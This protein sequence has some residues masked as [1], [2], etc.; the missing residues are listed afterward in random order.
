[1]TQRPRVVALVLVVLIVGSV[2]A[3]VSPAT[4]A[5]A[6]TDN[7]IVRTMDFF[8]TPSD[9]G[10]VEIELSYTIP[11]SVVELET[12]VPESSTVLETTGFSQNQTNTYTWNGEPAD[13]TIRFEYPANRTGE[14][15]YDVQMATGT[16]SKEGLSEDG[17]GNPAVGSG[18][19]L[20]YVDTGSWAIVPVPSIGVS[21]S[22]QG[23][24]APSFARRVTTDGP[25]V[26]GTSLVFLGTHEKQT[27]TIDD[28]QVTLVVPDAATLGPSER[29]VLDSIANASTTLRTGDKPEKILFVAAPTGVDW[30][31]NG[32]AKGDDAW[33]RA[34]NPVTDPNNVWLHEYIH[35]LQ[36]FQTTENARWTVEAMGEYYAALLTLEQGHIDFDAFAA[37]LEQ[38]EDQ[39][40]DDVVLSN[41]DTWTDL[42]N[43]VQGG[44][45]FGNLDR[46]MRLATDGS[47]PASHLLREMNQ[48]EK[49]VDHA[50]VRNTVSSLAGDDP[51]SYI[52]RYATTD[53]SPSMWTWR[54]HRDAFGTVPPRIV[55]DTN[56]TYTIT[57]AYRN[58]S[59]STIPTLVPGENLTFT[60]TLTNEGEAT[61]DYESAL[62][63]DGTQVSVSNGTLEGGSSTIIHHSYTVRTPGIHVFATGSE[64]WNVTVAEPATPTITDVTVS[65]V[66]VQPGDSVTV[67]VSVANR[68]E[69]PAE[70]N[71]SVAVDGSTIASW[72]E[73][74]AVGETSMR[75]VSV[76]LDEPGAH[77]ITVGEETV[78]VTVI[79]PTTTETT[80]PATTTSTGATP[81]TT[82]GTGTTQT[83]TTIPGF[84]I[85]VAIVGAV[86]ALG[87]W[88][89]RTPRG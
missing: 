16:A 5:A 75:T 6:E 38:G 70:G 73:R 13:P 53:R 18:E 54:Q 85:P 82:E 52:D 3:G 14:Y 43:Y 60:V 61:G 10:T 36:D 88:A 87:L 25:G 37:H 81:T 31:P 67:N 7:Q 58:Q 64:E 23:S 44:L 26:A 76:T 80:T 42:A 17:T 27:R 24:T 19:G 11:D 22:Y 41:P 56:A 71:V 2:G 50:F 62:T 40:Y 59:V 72:N 32:I 21:W 4:A 20:L 29:T 28:Q 12:T 78:T 57:G 86:L 9:P 55:S 79:E 65:R 34:D 89:R 83:E 84:G 49:A 39:R 8:L 68:E 35:I 51:A 46:R 1:M 74:L 77:E 47:E 69:R 48:R 33:V 63:V 15:L 45:V 66:Q 30:G